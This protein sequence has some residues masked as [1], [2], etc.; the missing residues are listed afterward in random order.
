[1]GLM[2]ERPDFVKD[3]VKPKNTE[4]KYIGGKWYLYERASQYF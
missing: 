1:M 4:I 2:H 3:F